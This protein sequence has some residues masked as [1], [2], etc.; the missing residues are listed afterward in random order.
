MNFVHDPL[1]MFFEQFSFNVF[2]LPSSLKVEDPSNDKQVLG[3]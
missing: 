2:F 1:L 3:Q